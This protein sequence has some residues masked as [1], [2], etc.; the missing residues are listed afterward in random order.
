MARRSIWTRAKHRVGLE[1]PF[2]YRV[3]PARFSLFSTLTFRGNPF[4]IS[5]VSDQ[6][7]A[8]QGDETGEEEGGGCNP[9]LLHPFFSASR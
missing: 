9:Y 1:R 7:L 8:P 6:L 5:S 3:A 2:L 4:C